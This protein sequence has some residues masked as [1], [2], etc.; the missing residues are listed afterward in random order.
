MAAAAVY[1]GS[2]RR[3]TAGELAVAAG[4]TDKTVERLVELAIVKPGDEGT[5]RPT[6]VRRVR[7]VLAL[8]TSGLGFEVVAA[9]ICD[10]RLSLDFIDEL[11]P[12]PIPL[13]PETQRQLV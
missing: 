8:E 6:D 9:A 4:T 13:L 11:A 3:Y 2:V 5:F 12:N 10:G 7:L 1:D